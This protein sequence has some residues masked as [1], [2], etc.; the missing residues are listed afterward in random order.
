MARTHPGVPA[1]ATP[2]VCQTWFPVPNSRPRWEGG[3]AV[4]CD[5]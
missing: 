5:G 3:C 4:R 1:G 2:T